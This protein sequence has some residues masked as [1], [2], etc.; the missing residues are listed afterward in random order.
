MGKKVRKRKDAL[1]LSVDIV[2]S[3]SSDIEFLDMIK[4]EEVLLYDIPEL[5]TACENILQK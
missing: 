3:E 1:N 2:T 5:K 4:K